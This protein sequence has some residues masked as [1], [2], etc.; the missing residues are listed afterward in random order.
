MTDEVTRD[1]V[2]RAV[3]W[4]LGLETPPRPEASAWTDLAWRDYWRSQRHFVLVTL[5][6]TLQ[7]LEGRSSG[8]SGTSP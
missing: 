3:D 7:T 4:V 6:K 8:P 5:L 1:D 2:H